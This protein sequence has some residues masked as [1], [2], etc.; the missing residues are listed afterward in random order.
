M[1]ESLYGGG[2]TNEGR[3]KGF[4]VPVWRGNIGVFFIGEIE[5]GCALMMTFELET[6]NDMEGDGSRGR[7]DEVKGHPPLEVFEDRQD[8]AYFYNHNQYLQYNFSMR[9]SRMFSFIRN[10]WFTLRSHCC[11]LIS[12]SR[13]RMC[14][15]NTRITLC[16]RPRLP[17]T[18]SIDTMQADPTSYF[19]SYFFY[20]V[21]ALNRYMG[22]PWFHGMHFQKDVRLRTRDRH[23]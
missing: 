4:R 15:F 18:L 19:F 9:H 6:I 8:K 2:A 12:N 7:G 5:E 23:I 11:I 21:N 3:N 10:F 20:L 16:R 14:I 1:D 13:C 22:R 17:V